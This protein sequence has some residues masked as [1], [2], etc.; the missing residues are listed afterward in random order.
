MRSRSVSQPPRP[1]E[2]VNYKPKRSCSGVFCCSE[3]IETSQLLLSERSNV[4]KYRQFYSLLKFSHKTLQDAYLQ[5]EQKFAAALLNWASE[6]VALTESLHR[7][8]V[9][10]SELA[11]TCEVLQKNSLT[12][13]RLDLIKLQV[14]TC[15][16]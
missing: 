13:E 14:C 7:C 12:K 16:S 8:Q 1:S 4:L 6:K 5:L 3:L 15:I 2:A 11:E 10:K 9:H